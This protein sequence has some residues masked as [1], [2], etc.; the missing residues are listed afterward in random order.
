MSMWMPATIRETSSGWR[1]E[2]GL[3]A[4]DLRHPEEADRP[5]R[6]RERAPP[7]GRREGAADLED[8]GAAG[9]VVVGAGGLVAEVRGEYDFAR[10]RIRARDRRDDDVVG[11]RDHLRVDPRR[12]DD[13]LAG[14]EPRTEVLRLAPGDHEGEAVLQLI[15]REMTPADEVAVVAGPR[16]RLVRERGEKTGGAPLEAGEAVDRREVPVGE[17]ELAAHVPAL[18]VGGLRAR[19]DVDQRRRDIR[20]LAVVGESH[21]QVRESRDAVPRR[22]DLFEKGGDRGPAVV[23]SGSGRT[24]SFRRREGARSRRS[25]V[26]PRPPSGACAPPRRRSPA[27]PGPDGSA[28]ARG[29]SR[30]WRRRRS[31][32]GSRRGPRPA[33]TG[34]RAPVPGPYAPAATAAKT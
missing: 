6:R 27:S 15:G 11:R 13:L 18:V 20:A 2:I 19:A 32:R 28:R 17:H 5:L 31:R 16:G 26:R 9:R 25:T 12:Q 8:G 4:R 23:A 30:A 7:D 3:R 29:R 10:R 22:R 1:D 33:R 21:G 34:S 24:S 14:G